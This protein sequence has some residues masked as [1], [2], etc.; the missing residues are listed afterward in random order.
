MSGL[1]ASFFGVSS[2]TAT[3]ISVKI[4]ELSRMGRRKAA[5]LILRQAQDDGR[6]EKI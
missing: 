4:I 2:L 5:E 6:R 1:G 3:A